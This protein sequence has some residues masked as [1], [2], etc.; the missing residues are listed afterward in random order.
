[1][2]SVQRRPSSS[3]RDMPTIAHHRSLTHENSPCRSTRASATMPPT[4]WSTPVAPSRSSVSC[5]SLP[6]GSSVRAW[7]TFRHPPHDA[8]TWGGVGAPGSVVG[9]PGSASR[10]AADRPVQLRLAQAHG[11]GRDLDALVLGDELEGLFEREWPGRRQTLELVGRRGADV[12][13]LL[14]LGRVDVHLVGPGV[15]ADDHSLVDLD[16][17]PHEEAS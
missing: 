11:L 2:T 13:E 17:G 3:G 1:M 5:P 8:T 4:S 16:T 15:L 12:G 10:P 6:T 14:L 9:G 7:T